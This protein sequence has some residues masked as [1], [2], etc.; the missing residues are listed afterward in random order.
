MRLRLKNMELNLENLKLE[1]WLLNRK[2]GG[3]RRQRGDY[4]SLRTQPGLFSL[5]I[6]I[7]NQFG[8]TE[9]HDWSGMGSY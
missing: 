4:F 7:S 6:S 2:D 5:A 8:Y 1:P 9:Y 3:F